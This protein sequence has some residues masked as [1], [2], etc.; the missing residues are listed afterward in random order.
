MYG[1]FLECKRALNVFVPI[2]KEK[3]PI[4]YSIS[5]IVKKKMKI[6]SE[7]LVKNHKGRVFC[8]TIENV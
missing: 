2:L 6:K 4:I 1:I 5:E 3:K 7:K 8:V